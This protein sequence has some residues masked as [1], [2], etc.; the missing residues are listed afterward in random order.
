MCT[1]AI[2]LNI[3]KIMKKILF[4]AATVAFLGTAFAQQAPVQDSTKKEC[5]EKKECKDKKDCKKE[6]KDKKGGKKK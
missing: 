4:L 3:K 6:C 1:F 2:S 5:K